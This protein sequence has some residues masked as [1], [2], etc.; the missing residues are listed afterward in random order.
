MSDPGRYV[1]GVVA[2]SGDTPTPHECGIDPA[3]GVEVLRRGALAAI[4]SRVRLEQ[5]SPDANDGRLAELAVRHE[6]VLES[7][8][9]AGL[10]VLPFR[11]GTVCASD[12]DVT[13]LLE[14][15]ESALTSALAAVEGK[16]EVGVRCSVDREQLRQ[17]I[18]EEDD[19][20]RERH[21]EFATLGPGAAH[22]RR[23]QFERLLADRVSREASRRTAALQVELARHAAAA[24]EMSYLLPSAEIDGFVE[25]AQAAAQELGLR[26]EVT[27][28]WPPFSF[29]ELETDDG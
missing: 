16:L 6:H 17:T 1:Y 22:L 2:A 15:R 25:R 4:T 19:D 10:S 23:K 27:G 18:L 21:A 9:V 28:P 3:F 13:T 29:A 14:T 7:F 20:L 12:G 8:L 11:F 26:V 24:R 5:L